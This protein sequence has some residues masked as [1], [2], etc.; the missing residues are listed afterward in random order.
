M[1][2]YIREYFGI[3]KKVVST[4]NAPSAIGPY[5]QA[6]YATGGDGPPQYLFLSGQLGIVPSTNEFATGDNP[7][8]A[9]TVQAMENIGQVLKAAHSAAT[10]NNIVKT[11]ILLVDMSAFSIVNE[12]YKQFFD[13]KRGYPARS[14][15]Q[16]S[17]L[18]KGG[19][20]EIEAIAV[21]S[22]KSQN[23]VFC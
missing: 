2:C 4:T 5:S 11:T 15:Y 18:P 22:S 20:V 23:T 6:V 21:L 9:Q 12:A 13:E 8:H 10:F 17:A 16:V 1:S 3:G 14:C 19:L 7:Y